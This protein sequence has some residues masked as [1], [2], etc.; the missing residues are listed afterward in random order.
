M[1]EWKLW[2]L[3]RKAYISRWNVLVTKSPI[4]SRERCWIW[5]FGQKKPRSQRLKGKIDIIPMERF[6]I[7]RGGVSMNQTKT[8]DAPDGNNGYSADGNKTQ[9]PKESFHDPNKNKDGPD[10]S[11]TKPTMAPPFAH[12]LLLRPS[13]WDPLCPQLWKAGKPPEEGEVEGWRHSWCPRPFP[14]HIGPQS[15]RGEWG[16]SPLDGASRSQAVGGDKLREGREA[17]FLTTKHHNS[18]NLQASIKVSC[19]H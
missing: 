2:F 14:Q 16:C 7:H 10:G 3:Q 19:C 11:K 18:S 6:Y 8:K 1:L 4:E 15:L 12:L 5:T 9:L 13:P 17:A